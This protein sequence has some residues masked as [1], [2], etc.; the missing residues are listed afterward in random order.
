MVAASA[1]P[2]REFMRRDFI[3]VAPQESLVEAI[4]IMRLARLR[5]LLVARDGVLVGV[6]SYRDIQDESLT[7]HDGVLSQSAGSA[8]GEV[9]VEK[10]M[11][12]VPDR[13]APDTTL[14]AAASR[15]LRLRVGCL[16]VVEASDRGDQLVGLITETDLLRAAYG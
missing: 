3:T 16:P 14:Q 2:V 12:S 11:I 8:F 15:I 13:I 1:R 7:R 6:L 9:P 5:H 10:T 4:Q